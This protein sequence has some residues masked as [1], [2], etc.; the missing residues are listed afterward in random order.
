MASTFNE[1]AVHPAVHQLPNLVWVYLNQ[2]RCKSTHIFPA[3]TYKITCACGKDFFYFVKLK[4]GELNK[5]QLSY[6]MKVFNILKQN[7]MPK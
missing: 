2:E 4:I 6:Q 5:S 3:W 7:D 1:F